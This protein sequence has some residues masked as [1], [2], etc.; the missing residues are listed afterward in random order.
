MRERDVWEWEGGGHRVDG[1]GG[2]E[3][4]KA[5]VCEGEGREI[6]MYVKEK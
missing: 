3:G 4:E 1:G 6:L 5:G 2:E